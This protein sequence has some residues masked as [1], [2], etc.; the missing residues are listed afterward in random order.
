VGESANTFFVAI[1]ESVDVIA[2]QPA[3][4]SRKTGVLMSFNFVTGVC[5]LKR[6]GSRLSSRNRD[7]ASR[8]R[9]C[10]KPVGIAIVMAMLGLLS[11]PA[12]FAGFV[13]Q[14]VDTATLP[15]VGTFQ[16]NVTVSSLPPLILKAPNSDD[17]YSNTVLMA[18]QGMGTLSA[19]ACSSPPGGELGSGG[20]A[21]AGGSLLHTELFRITSTSLP[22][23]APV[24]VSFN[25]GA[26]RR[27][28]IRLD[29]DFPGIGDIAQVNGSAAI[30]FGINNMNPFLFDG[31][32]SH[33]VTAI[34]GDTMSKSGL[35]NGPDSAEGNFYTLINGKLEKN[36]APVHVGDFIRLSVSGSISASSGANVLVVADATTQI[37]LTWGLSPFE[38]PIQIVSW[39]GLQPAPDNGDLTLDALIMSLPPL[40]STIVPEPATLVQALV[41]GLGIGF[42]RRRGFRPSPK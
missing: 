20:T 24:F 12:S 29:F 9:F 7:I 22:D 30:S 18:P 31:A 36:V 1:I 10:G 23:G 40:P 16:D 6:S 39:P 5:F 33:S 34:G 14:S 26:T 42:W 21:Q 27:D 11:P 25:V 41:A 13:S 28:S 38:S 17:A 3:N 32:Y 15:G 8:P 4:D 35:F 19:H 2:R 37:S